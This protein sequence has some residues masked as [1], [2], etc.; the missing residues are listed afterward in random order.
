MPKQNK[1]SPSQKNREDKLRMRL[2]RHEIGRVGRDGNPSVAISLYNGYHQQKL[3]PEVLGE[4]CSHVGALLFKIEMGVKMGLTLSSSTSKACQWNSTFRK[5]VIPATVTEICDK[6]KGKRT[7]E[8]VSIQAD[9]SSFLP[10]PEVLDE[11]YALIVESQPVATYT[12][13]YP[14]LLQSLQDPDIS[15]INI[16]SHCKDI[17]SGYLC[18]DYQATN[19]EAATR[20]QAISPLWFQHRMGRVTA[21]KAH[22]VWTRKDTTSPDVLVKRIVRYSAYDLNEI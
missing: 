18:S 13:K 6:I 19:L 12:E 5:E 16:D 14:K 1:K 8:V 11:L 20:N 22:D 15:D 3:S 10:Q 4:V 2:E 9:G 7:K 17:F 21:S